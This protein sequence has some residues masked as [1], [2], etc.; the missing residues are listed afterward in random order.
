MRWLDGQL[1][2]DAGEA[3]TVRDV[4]EA[5]VSSGGRAKTASAALNSKGARTRRGMP[6]TDIAVGRVLQNP[7]LRDLVTE[8]LWKRLSELFRVREAVGT[9]PN[10]QSA[11]PLGGSLHCTC[12]GRMY[13]RGDGPRGRFC[14]RICAAKLA[15]DT[16]E[17]LFVE[18]L[19]GIELSATDLIDACAGNPRAAELTRI[20]GGDPVALSEIWSSLDRDQAGQLVDLLVARIIV[21][22][23]EVSVILAESADSKP[24]NTL[25]PANSLPS[26]HGSE[27]ANGGS[28][29]PSVEKSRPDVPTRRIVEPKAFRISHVAALLDLPRSTVYDLTRTRALPSI[30]TGT[31]GRVVLVPA[32]AVAEFLEKKRGRR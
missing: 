11:H 20:L 31:N 24:K 7:A 14:C 28:T 30:R 15:Q 22:H 3:G 17:R 2:A 4:V 1:V 29:N 6:W 32:S 21:G 23:D 9:A 12:G 16:L 25:S 26:Q 10:R 8:D 18:V 19:G 27:P 13:L 5:F